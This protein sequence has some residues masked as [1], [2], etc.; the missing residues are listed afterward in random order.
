MRIIIIFLG[1][2]ML[3]GAI[4]GGIF[5]P[6]TSRLVNWTLLALREVFQFLEK[7]FSLTS[8]YFEG[9]GE[10]FLFLVVFF[11]RWERIFS[12]P[13]D[14]LNRMAMRRRFGFT[15]PFYFEHPDPESVI[16]IEGWILLKHHGRELSSRVREWQEGLVDEMKLP[17][18]REAKKELTDL[19][20][21]TYGRYG[22]NFSNS[23]SR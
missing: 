19:H 4:L 21:A 1:A 23:T 18:S 12:L 16:S 6:I 13:L 14:F 11:K 22:C 15:G 3:L 17:L 20:Y 7:N 5:L 10:I 9:K 2:D 8:R